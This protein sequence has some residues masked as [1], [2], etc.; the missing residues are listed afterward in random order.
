MVNGICGLRF[1]ND[2]AK[3]YSFLFRF[4]FWRFSFVDLTRLT[5]V[6]CR[7]LNENQLTGT[8]PNAISSLKRLQFLSVILVVV[9]GPDPVCGW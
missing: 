9:H 6:L 8:I 3:L 4:D 1:G 7:Y 5:P 2:L